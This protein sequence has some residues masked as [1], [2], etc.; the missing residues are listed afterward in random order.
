MN[1]KVL[2]IGGAGY[3]GTVLVEALSAHGYRVRI[4]DS[5]IYGKKPVKKFEG[6]L[7]VEIIEGD[8]RNIE[9]VNSSMAGASSVILL[10]AVVG[11]PA[12]ANRPEKQ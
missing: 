10:A 6:N 1:N 9:C 12:L 8:I 3:L 4:L 11:D 2:V 5:F 7:C